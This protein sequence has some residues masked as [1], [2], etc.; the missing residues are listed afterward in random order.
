V[1]VDR[2]HVLATPHMDRHAAYVGLT[3]HRD[4]VALHY[5]RE[6]FPE[7]ARLARTLGRERAKDTGLDYDRED[8]LVRR[9]AAR[10]GMAPESEIIVRER[11]QPALRR[12]RFAGL[13]LDAV[14][15]E[16]ER[17][18]EP[19]PGLAETVAA[20][21]AGF[22]ERFEAHRRQQAQERAQALEL[23]RVQALDQAAARELVGQWDRVLAAYSAAL[24]RLEADPTLGGTREQM[25]LFARGVREQ[26][27]AARVLRE[28]GEAFGMAERPNLARIVSAREPERV[29]GGIMAKAED[30]M[31]E[32]LRAE[33]E[34]EAVRQRELE[35]ARL[36]PRRDR[37]PSL[38]W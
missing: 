30:G 33:A 1:T 5:A 8:E 36:A 35:A 11:E 26:P 2:A 24:P 6:D 10:R 23:A 15:V 21:R 38:G 37:G 22:R 13:A 34:R 18:P 3:R 29:V 9:Y 27:G 7:P 20:G 16:R 28:Q 32:H 19:A 14:S 4:G 17:A 12:G 31:R 25:A